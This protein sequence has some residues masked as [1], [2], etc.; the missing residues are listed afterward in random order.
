VL[1]QHYTGALGVGNA[2]ELAVAVWSQLAAGLERY[3]AAV[4]DE[5]DPDAAAEQTD[6][7]GNIVSFSSFTAQLFEFSLSVVAQRRL[8]P[9]VQRHL[10]SICAIAI[11]YLQVTAA[12]KEDWSEDPANFVFAEDDSSLHLSPRNSAKD[13]L[14]RL[15]AFIPGAEDAVVAATTEV[16]SRS[17]TEARWQLTEAGLTAAAVLAA[18]ADDLRDEGA[19]PSDKTKQFLVS[20]TSE[21]LIPI[22]QRSLADPSTEPLIVGRALTAAAAFT[23]FISPDTARAFLDIAATAI[24]P[25]APPII[26][27]SAMRTVHAIAESQR[28]SELECASGCDKPALELVSEP[29]ALR[30]CAGIAAVADTLTSDQ[31]E[32]IHLCLD[33]LCAVCVCAPA[34]GVKLESAVSPLLLHSWRM[35]FCDPFST[36]YVI[37]TITAMGRTPSRELLAGLRAHLLEPVLASLAEAN[38]AAQSVMFSSAFDVV[39]AILL[40]GLDATGHTVLPL[41]APQALAVWKLIASTL[42]EA[43]DDDDVVQSTVS[44][45]RGLLACVDAATLALFLP[46]LFAL[47]QSL[48]L[49]QDTS[50]IARIAACALVTYLSALHPDAVAGSLPAIFFALSDVLVAPESTALAAAIVVALS[51]EIIRSPDAT[52]TTLAGHV[53][54]SGQSALVGFVTAFARYFNDVNGFL[55]LRVAAATAETLLQHPVCVAAGI[56]DLPVPA[57]PAPQPKGIMTRSRSHREGVDVTAWSPAPYGARAV[58][59]LLA[60]LREEREAGGMGDTD[61][62]YVGCGDDEDITC[63]GTGMVDSGMALAPD[64]EFD[65][66]HPLFSVVFLASLPG[67]IRAI[68]TAPSYSARFGQSLLA[69]LDKPEAMLLQECSQ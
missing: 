62:D 20:C 3:Q 19:E 2:T 60:L 35:C 41:A 17:L 10:P 49:G 30:I 63:F 22:I 54:S 8:F 68:V 46:D 65:R 36:S 39:H 33:S 59:C 67:R 52:L 47:L 26:S 66:R 50:P 56:P 24:A 31:E 57:R 5:S 58:A 55:A 53:T 61:D 21:F 23:A 45:V 29:V 14:N 34:A 18:W 64:Q 32:L 40:G 9:A 7:A 44:A 16:L 25:P 27:I 37:D 38:P 42:T 11:A 28:M 6:S 15:L 1:I 12:E 51:H 13:L 48:L 43:G 69:I 4:V